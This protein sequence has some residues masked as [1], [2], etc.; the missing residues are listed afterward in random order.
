MRNSL[1]LNGRLSLS[2]SSARYNS[3]TKEELDRIEIHLI[4]KYVENK[5]QFQF[6]YDCSDEAEKEIERLGAFEIRNIESNFYQKI[7]S[8]LLERGLDV[9]KINALINEYKSYINTLMRG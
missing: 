1:S 9:E 2:V 6:V 5:N 3:Y 8:G 4:E 7:E